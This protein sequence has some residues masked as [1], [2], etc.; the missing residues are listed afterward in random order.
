MI[1]NI[2]V[3]HLTSLHFRYDVRIF[4]KE[5]KSLARAGY[6]V[7]LVVADGEGNEIVEG[8]TIY[9]IGKK[10]KCRIQRMLLTANKVFKKAISLNA[11]IYHIHDPELIPVGLKLKKKGLKIIFDAHED[12]PKQLLSKPYIPQIVRSS[13]SKL[14]RQYEKKVCK[15]FDAIVTATPSI[16]EKFLKINSNTIDVNNF[17]ILDELFMETTNSEGKN[18]ICYIG[19]ISKIRGIEELV[20]A[21]GISKSDTKLF[22]CGDFREPELK[23]KVEKF[24]GWSKVKY[25]GLIDRNDIC[26]VLSQSIAGIVTLWPEPNHIESQPIKMFEYMSAGI[27]VI[28]SNF[29]LWMQIVEG[30]KCGICVDP[31]NPQEISTAID[32]LANNPETAQEMGKNGRLAVVQR[33]NWELEE[34]KLLEL[35]SKI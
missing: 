27:P 7:S 13:L 10:P 28:Y 35:Y 6:N 1:K 4:L 14:I 9:D 30:N 20:K 31:L 15:Q 2:Q 25:L 29:P 18:N 12:L 16:C 34:K 8:V 23:N 3:C 5:C 17:P 19:G 32:F 21:I 11:T 22:L 33:Y 24:S 26:E